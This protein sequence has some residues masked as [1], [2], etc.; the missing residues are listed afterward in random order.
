MI[1]AWFGHPVSYPAVL[2]LE[3]VAHAARHF[4]FIVPAGLGVQEAGLIGVG[5]LLGLDMDVALALSLAK[6]ARELLYGLPSL[7]LWQWL[8][9]RVSVRG[10]DPAAL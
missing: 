9:E 10:Q 5:H 8:E 7:A 2:A 4:I 1:L 6:R 3:S